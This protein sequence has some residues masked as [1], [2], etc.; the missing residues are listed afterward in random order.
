MVASQT[1]FLG[2]MGVCKGCGHAKSAD[3]TLITDLEEQDEKVN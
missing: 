3:L 2:V 1:M